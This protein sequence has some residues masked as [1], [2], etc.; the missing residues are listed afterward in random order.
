MN[1]RVRQS[2]GHG[3]KSLPSLLREAA[4]PP[5][6]AASAPV[7][8]EVDPS[9]M[10]QSDDD[11]VA[12]VLYALGDYRG[13]NILEIVS[14]VQRGFGHMGLVSPHNPE[15][16]EHGLKILVNEGAVI[17]TKN[18]RAV[19]RIFTLKKGYSMH[20]QASA[21]RNIKPRPILTLNGADPA[22]TVNLSEGLMVC[23]WKLMSDYKKR[24]QQELCDMLVAYGVNG[25]VAKDAFIKAK[26]SK[27]WFDQ[28]SSGRGARYSMRKGI[29]M[30]TPDNVDPESFKFKRSPGDIRDMSNRA[31]NPETAVGIALQAAAVSVKSPR[32]QTYVAPV[33]EVKPVV[34]QEEAPVVQ[35][36][37]KNED[38][39]DQCIWKVMSDYKQYT[40]TE[41]GLL[42]AEIGFHTKS[43][44]T[45]IGVIYKNDAWFDREP[46]T[47]GKGF[48]YTLRRNIEMP[49]SQAQPKK[50]EMNGA[51]QPAVKE[52][53]AP[54][55]SQ[56]MNLQG[57]GRGIE[58]AAADSLAKVDKQMSAQPASQP[59]VTM[60]IMDLVKKTA[61]DPDVSDYDRQMAVQMLAGLNTPAVVPDEAVE[62]INLG[63][64]A[65]TQ[66]LK[67]NVSIKGMSFTFKQAD[68]LTRE[69]VSIG[70]GKGEHAVDNGSFLKTT[71]S[72][73][74]NQFTDFELDALAKQLLESGFG[75]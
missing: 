60:N 12:S 33:I 19:A 36:V 16:I 10:L 58:E 27:H 69:L 13:R 8:N 63:D 48:V 72:I 52:T 67:F 54:A 3:L 23:I 30:P 11:E 51:A 4:T 59:M 55:V 73:R 14:E 22:G 41:V 68:T 50:E 49:P 38:G 47:K 7:N 42:L 2:V 28:H 37:L 6:L 65:D 74:D 35:H 61:N 45:R 9:K 1:K 43:V 26:C 66:M 24:T 44:A 34:K 20:T 53:G 62:A 71:R 40:A 75:N 57:I 31:P 29:S 39:V 46:M 18:G 25:E 5:M 17:S 64:L 70:F 56:Q 21:G 15:D 32:Q